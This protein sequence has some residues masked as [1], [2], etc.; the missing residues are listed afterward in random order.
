M[1]CGLARA[2]GAETPPGRCGLCGPLDRLVADRPASCRCRTAFSY[3]STSSSA[4]LV[5]TRYAGE[6]WMLDHGAGSHPTLCRSKSH[7]RRWE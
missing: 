2:A 6:D 7:R 5:L 3:R 1:A 4:S